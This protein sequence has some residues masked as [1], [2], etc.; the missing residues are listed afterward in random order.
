MA[1]LLIVIALV[2][3]LAAPAAAELKVQDV[4]ARHGPHGPERATL[5]VFPGDELVLTYTL[6]GMQTDTDGKVDCELRQTITAPDGKVL[7]DNKTPIKEA[8]AFGGGHLPGF[9]AASFG[10]NTRPGK[11]VVGVTITDKLRDETVSFE[12][13]AN[14]LKPDLA[15]VRPRLSYD[16]EGK[17]GA[18]LTNVLG[19]RLFFRLV[20]VGFDRSQKKI[21]LTMT[22]QHYDE[23]GKEL[24]PKPLTVKTKSDDEEEVAKADSATFNGSFAC[25]RP[26]TFKMK[27]VI[28]DNV[29]NKSATFE[30]PLKVVE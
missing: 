28:T 24:M 8:L 29:T 17:T 10:V 3:G 6:T 14:V 12:R 7:V 22:V 15:I 5:D 19:T 20:A 1:R 23:K 25:N 16:P 9:A 13:T 21:D 18:G 30:A 27:I 11:Y 26:G 4:K 2:T